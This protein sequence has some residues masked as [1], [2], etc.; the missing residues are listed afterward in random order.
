MMRKPW[1]AALFILVLATLACST[2]SPST[3]P[4]EADSSAPPIDATEPSVTDE[5]PTQAAPAEELTVQPSASP[6]PENDFGSIARGHIEALTAIDARVSGSDNERAAGQYI[7]D[8]FTQLGYTPETQSFSAWDEDEYEFTS[9][10]VIAVK[11]GTS[12]REII[13]GAHYDSGNES[14]GADDNASGVGVM[15][16][17]AAHIVRL[18]TPYT[19]RFI[20]FGSEENDLDGSYYY[21]ELM[22]Q[23]ARDNTIAMVNLDSLAAGDNLYVYSDEGADA[24]LRDW[25]LTWAGDNGQPLQTIRDVELTDGGYYVAD[26]GA[27]AERGMPYI[28][29]EATNWTLGD[30][31]GYTQVDPQYGDEGYI[32]H[33]QYDNLE[34]LDATFPGRVNEHMRIFVSALYAVCTEF[35]LP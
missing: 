33:T 32:W 3:P 19:I 28:Y 30:Q 1:Q 6:A 2:V 5:L 13:V 16:E 20:A 25:V 14:L 22:G 29:F 15:L 34:Y 7:I 17:V 18:E 23:P 24:F 21:A 31:D 11:Q 27:F 8:T 35:K 9:R 26:Y 4:V 12:A 10:N